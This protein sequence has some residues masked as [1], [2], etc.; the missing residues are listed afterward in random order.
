MFAPLAAAPL[1]LPPANYFSDTTITIGGRGYS[2]QVWID[3]TARLGADVS[4]SQAEA[5]LSA[6]ASGRSASRAPRPI[7]LI[8]TSRDVCGRVHAASFCRSSCCSS[9]VNARSKI[10]AGSPSGIV[11]EGQ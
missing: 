8:E 2:P 5:V 3:V 9:S 6:V 11:L 4:I 10:A 7:R 1:V